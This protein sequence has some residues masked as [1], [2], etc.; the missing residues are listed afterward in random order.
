M[1]TSVNVSGSE[2][3]RKISSVRFLNGQASVQDAG[4]D[5]QLILSDRGL[6]KTALNET[7]TLSKLECIEIKTN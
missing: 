3:K 7:K 4:S 6:V 1:T 5:N 2:V